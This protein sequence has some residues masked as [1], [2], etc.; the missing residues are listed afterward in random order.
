MFGGRKKDHRMPAGQAGYMEITGAVKDGDCRI[1]NVPGG[2][3]KE[4]GC[5]N[6]FEPESL[7]TKRFRCGDCE[8][9][10]GRK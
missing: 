8:Y 9:L 10:K 3:S 1:V 7:K 4:L 6:E 2:V 5:C